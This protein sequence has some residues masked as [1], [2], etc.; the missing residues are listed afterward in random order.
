LYVSTLGF[1][2][3]AG[4]CGGDYFASLYGYY[5]IDLAIEPSTWGVLKSLYR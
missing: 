1:G 5:W 3:A 4:E 2:P